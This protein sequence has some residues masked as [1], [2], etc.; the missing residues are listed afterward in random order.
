[1]KAKSIIIAATF[2]L[3]AGVLCTFGDADWESYSI[4]GYKFYSFTNL[5]E[6]VSLL[7]TIL[8]K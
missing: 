5:A 2:T 3:Q 1:M 7:L 6:R 4:M 8:N